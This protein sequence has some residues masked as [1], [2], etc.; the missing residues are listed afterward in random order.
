MTVCRRVV[1]CC[2]VSIVWFSSATT[3]GAHSLHT[4]FTELTEVRSRGVVRATIRVFADDFNAA[5]RRSFPRAP[6]GV[7]AGTLD[8]REVTY[9]AR[10]FSVSDARGHTVPLTACGVR[11]SDGLLWICIE[12]AVPNGLISVMVRNGMLAEVFD[13]QVN[14]VQGT[15]GGVRRSL[16]FVRNDP[17]KALVQ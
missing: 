9:V 15:V 6:V 5:V 1:A 16:L 3:L 4:T 8:V 11:R 2:L 13:D 14:V 12:A 17:P 10:S 7:A